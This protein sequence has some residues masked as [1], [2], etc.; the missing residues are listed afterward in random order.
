[1]IASMIRAVP[2]MEVGPPGSRVEGPRAQTPPGQ[3]LQ[4]IKRPEVRGQADRR[5]GRIHEPARARHRVVVRREVTDP[6]PGPHPAESADEAV[7]PR[8]HTHDYKR[9]GTTTLFAALNVLT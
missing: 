7:T 4:S 9:H 6:G 3:D 5:R 8:D 2:G 1:M